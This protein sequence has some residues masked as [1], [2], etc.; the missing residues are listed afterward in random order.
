ME[1]TVLAD[2]NTY[3]DKYYLGE[4]GFS[5]YI[6]DGSERI[7]FD[8]GYSDVFYKNARAMGIDLG[9]L[10]TVVFSHGHDDHTGGLPYLMKILPQ[11]R[12]IAHPDT[13]GEKRSRGINAGSAVR[14]D[15]LRQHYSLSLS[16]EPQKVS[17]HITFL[18]E[19]PALNSFEMRIQFGEHETPAGFAPDFVM[20][21]SALVYET[22]GGIYII[23]GCSHAGICS[24]AEYAKQIFQKPVRGIIGGF[25]LKK[26]DSRTEQTIA[27]L[28]TL[29]LEELYPCHCTSFAVQAAI[30]AEIPIEEVG[31]GMK[32]AW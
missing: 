27:Y 31:V 22:E 26:V 30:H 8:C 5:V 19:I 32:L 21:D 6:E 14:E 20:E 17:E 10:T 15:E 24:I 11:G 28:K 2:N 29:N 23:T 1:L 13:F 3:I 9:K 16:R 25:H 18:G 4:P 7:L 12:I